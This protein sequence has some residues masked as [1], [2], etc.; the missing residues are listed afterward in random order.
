MSA[1]DLDA[2]D[3]TLRV[4]LAC[5]LDDGAGTTRVIDHLV[6]T[7][8]SIHIPTTASLTRMAD[9]LPSDLEM[10][11]DAPAFLE[12]VNDTLVSIYPPEPRSNL[13]VAS[14]LFIRTAQKAV[15][16]CPIENLRELVG[17]MQEGLSVWLADYYRVLTDMV[18]SGRFRPFLCTR[19]LRCTCSRSAHRSRSQNS[20][21]AI[22]VWFSWA[23]RTNYKPL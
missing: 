10:L 5:A 23:T 3:A 4:C 1:D 14:L 8:S 15:D 19:Q 13:K 12:A 18:W 17:V 20:G 7:T 9:L 2:W 6:G 22:G 21:S 16:T 11:V